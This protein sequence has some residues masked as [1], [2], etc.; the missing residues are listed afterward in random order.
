MNAG[1][2]SDASF[3]F[4]PNGDPVSYTRNIVTT[5]TCKQCHGPLFKAH[6]GDR[7]FDQA[8]FFDQVRIEPF[9]LVDFLKQFGRLG[10]GG[11][12]GQVELGAG[13]QVAII[14]RHLDD[15]GQQFF[16]FRQIALLG[17]AGQDLRH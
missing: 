16:R 14:E 11:D 5:D 15:F 17:A 7:L 9:H 6:G 2:T 8:G 13:D 4:V 10:M 12:I 1:A 3:D